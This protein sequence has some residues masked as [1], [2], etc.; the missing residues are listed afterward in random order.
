MAAS[1]YGEG[2]LGERYSAF[3]SRY[4]N[5]RTLRDALEKNESCA[6]FAEVGWKGVA[7]FRNGVCSLL[8]LLPDSD[9]SEEEIVAKIDELHPGLTWSKN[10]K[11]ECQDDICHGALFPE[12]RGAYLIA[13]DAQKQAKSRKSLAKDMFAQ[14]MTN[15]LLRLG[16]PADFDEGVLLWETSQMRIGVPL[17]SSDMAYLVWEPTRKRLRDKKILRMTKDLISVEFTPPSAPSRASGSGDLIGYGKDSLYCLIRNTDSPFSYTVCKSALR[18][19]DLREMAQDLQFPRPKKPVESEEKPVVTGDHAELPAP[20]PPV[21]GHAPAPGTLP[22]P[23]PAPIKPAE[24]VPD[25]P[26]RHEDLLQS[27]IESLGRE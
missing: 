5:R 22:E 16:D 10:G 1:A 23:A 25:V 13:T 19:D 14:T 12:G 3:E 9:R 27:F 2:I 21:P 17:S 15:A 20:A 4:P 11:R 6:A 26:T 8:F 7:C 24:T 18:Y